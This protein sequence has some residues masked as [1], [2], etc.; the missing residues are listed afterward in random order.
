[1]MTRKVKRHKKH[2]NLKKRKRNQVFYPC[3]KMSHLHLFPIY[4]LQMY[5]NYVLNAEKRI[6]IMNYCLKYKGSV[7]NA[8]MNYYNDKYLIRC[9]LSVNLRRNIHFT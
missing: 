4:V 1:M 3:K 8:E 7:Q 5:Y 2:L 9:T 6:Q